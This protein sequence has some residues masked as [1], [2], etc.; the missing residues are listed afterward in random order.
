MTGIDIEKVEN[1]AQSVVK[2]TINDEKDM[3]DLEVLNY[4][5]LLMNYTVSAVN[6]MVGKKR[7]SEIIK[8]ELS[9]ANDA[10]RIKR[11]TAH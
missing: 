5:I 3:N 4:M 2:K 9:G 11:M 8:K 1:I 7:T 10:E 6:S